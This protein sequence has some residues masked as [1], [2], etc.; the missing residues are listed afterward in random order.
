MNVS[1][2]EGQRVKSSGEIMEILEALDLTGGLA[3]RN[4]PAVI[5][6]PWPIMRPCARRCTA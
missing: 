4:W 3:G 6:R 5:T 1:R 2:A